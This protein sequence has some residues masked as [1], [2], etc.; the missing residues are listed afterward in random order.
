LHSHLGTKD[1]EEVE[2]RIGSG[3]WKA[4]QAYKA[5]VY[6]IAKEIGAMATVLNGAVDALLLTGGMANSPR[7][8]AARRERVGW[9]APVVVYPG[10]DELR[11][12]TEG[13]LRFLRHEED[14]RAFGLAGT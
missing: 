9:I 7:L 14:V 6:Q 10:Q 2:R 5:M 13:V 8:I 12:L 3:E 11:A 4:A 1:L